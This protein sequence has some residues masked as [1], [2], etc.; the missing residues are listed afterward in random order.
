MEG[1]IEITIDGQTKSITGNATTGN[2]SSSP[3]KQ[4]TIDGET[5]TV[6]VYITPK[7]WNSLEPCWNKELNEATE[8]E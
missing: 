3:T 7:N 4:I 5:E 6:S 8:E 1:T 2:Y